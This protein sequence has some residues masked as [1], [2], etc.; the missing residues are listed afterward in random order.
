MRK[1]RFW[2]MIPFLLFASAC[3]GSGDAVVTTTTSTTSVPVT[4][5][6]LDPASIFEAKK[7]DL[8]S[9][10]FIDNQGSDFYKEHK[11]FATT[12]EIQNILRKNGIFGN[13]ELQ[14]PGFDAFTGAQ[15]QR[16]LCDDYSLEGLVAI[17]APPRT[18]IVGRYFTWTNSNLEGA[19]AAAMFFHGGM[20]IFEVPNSG[21]AEIVAD[22]FAVRGGT[23]EL[24]S[25]KYR[26]SNWAK[27][28]Q[29]YN[30]LQRQQWFTEQPLL[31]AGVE[32]QRK[33]DVK[34]DS[35]FCSE[36]C[37]GGPGFRITQTSGRRSYIRTFRV[38]EYAELG[39]LTV[40]ELNV[41]RNGTKNSP[42]IVELV[43]LYAPAV[44]EL[45]ITMENKLADYLAD[46]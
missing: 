14:W 35:R 19:T 15:V 29:I 33:N 13:V 24:T 11:F 34:F 27:C 31:D 28:E 23:C 20:T 7:T 25:F 37:V 45:E 22:Y 17:V 12:E 8:L 43:N 3:S 16:E 26:C 4:T 21:L 1:Q 39:L 5:T 40:I 42:S 9:E 41:S 30:P 32:I 6:T 44:A 18:R 2:G 38:I 36:T 10:L 46:W